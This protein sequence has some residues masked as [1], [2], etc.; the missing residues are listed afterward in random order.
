MAGILPPLYLP[1]PGAKPVVPTDAKRAR[2]EDAK[3]APETYGLLFGYYDTIEDWHRL[4]AL[5]KEAKAME[6]SNQMAIGVDGKMDPRLPTRAQLLRQLDG[7]SPWFNFGKYQCGYEDSIEDF[8]KSIREQSG[9]VA[10]AATPK[11]EVVGM[12]SLDRVPTPTVWGDIV[13]NML[14]GNDYSSAL[15]AELLKCPT[16]FDHANVRN[17]LEKELTIIKFYISYA[18][19]GG[20]DQRPTVIEDDPKD[21]DCDSDFDS[22]CDSDSDFVSA[23]D[24]DGFKHR[25]PAL[26]GTMK[27]I[28]NSMSTLIDARY[29][30][31][32]V[33]RMINDATWINALDC[34]ACPEKATKVL[35]RLC[36]YDLYSLR[37]AIPAWTKLGFEP[38]PEDK[39]KKL[40][41]EEYRLYRPV[42]VENDAIPVIEQ[43]TRRT[44]E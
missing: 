13:R 18:C 36:Y 4:S 26:K 1:H 9:Q 29:V 15:Q 24:P 14:T 23:P 34:W 21:S 25:T 3:E 35:R 37:A 44:N 10:V 7:K 43:P 17:I 40:P 31:P 22:D 2:T 8:L 41:D 12:I 16:L 39:P 20:G 42:F 27:F 5:E 32:T 28:L 33:K 30:Q 6:P 38:R 19:T 11:G